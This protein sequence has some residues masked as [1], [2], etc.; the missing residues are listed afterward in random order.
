MATTR[1]DFELAVAA[2]WQGRDKQ[3]AAADA[4]ESTA[5]GA[6]KAVRG[7]SHFD[8]MVAL[9]S[10][11]FTDAGYPQESIGVT[12]GGVTLPS[13]FRPTKRWDLV[14]VH[15]GVLVAAIEL[16]GIGGSYGKNYNNRVEEALGSSID[17]ARANREGL[18][19]PEKPW[20]G[21]FFLMN[22]EAE[23]RRPL[24]PQ[25]GPFPVEE[26]WRG[27]S[28][29]ERF[30]VTASRLLDEDFYDAV[31]YVVSSPPDPGPREPVPRLDWQ[32][33]CAGIKA[34]IEFLSSLGLP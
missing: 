7:G 31:C 10:R 27:R 33:F 26:F 23:S 32:H 25:E 12:I 9:I 30:E 19:G 34:R 22:D 2:F 15:K 6:A 8:P 29:Q 3:L 14:V 16:K 4:I 28:Y 11:F 5:E 21:Y 1:E 20:M 13:H 17:L 24:K 18:V